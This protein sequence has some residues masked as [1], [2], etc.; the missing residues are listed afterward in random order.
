M[1]DKIKRASERRYVDARLQGKCYLLGVAG[2]F[3]MSS[4]ALSIER[5]GES[6]ECSIVQ[7]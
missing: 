7:F 2:V 1:S 5:D 3:D 6:L 4:R